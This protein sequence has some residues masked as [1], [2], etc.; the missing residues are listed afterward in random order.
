MHTP[1]AASNR[2]KISELMSFI[3]E[4][5]LPVDSPSLPFWARFNEPLRRRRQDYGFTTSCRF[6]STLDTGPLAKSY[7]CGSLTRLS[8]NHFQSALACDCSAIEMEFHEIE[9]QPSALLRQQ[10]LEQ[11]V[12]AIGVLLGLRIAG[13]HQ[14]AFVPNL[15]GFLLE[16]CAVNRVMDTVAGVP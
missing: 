8:A 9:T 1:W 4:R 15:V 16:L 2:Y 3:A 5:P 7:P 11:K 14:M 6:A 13:D 12:V 10:H